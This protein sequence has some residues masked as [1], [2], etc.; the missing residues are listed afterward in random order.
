MPTIEHLSPVE[1]DVHRGR[2]CAFMERYAAC[3]IRPV[4]VQKALAAY[5]KLVL[6]LRRLPD[7]QEREAERE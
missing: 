6:D 2:C 3:G 1:R 5:G 4:E 7:L